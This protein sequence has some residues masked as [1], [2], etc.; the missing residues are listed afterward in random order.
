MVMGCVLS[1]IT[2]NRQKEFN[3]ILLRSPWLL[4]ENDFQE[5]VSKCHGKMLSIP[6]E[7]FSLYSCNKYIFCNGKSFLLSNKIILHYCLV[8]IIRGKIVLY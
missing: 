7:V 3:S 8:V 1:V 4:L 2:F 5:T 6:I